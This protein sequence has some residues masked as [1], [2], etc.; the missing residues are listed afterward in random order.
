MKT[1]LGSVFVIFVLVCCAPKGELPKDRN[2][3]D[4]SLA[5]D[6]IKV[7]KESELKIIKEQKEIIL[8][9]EA[10]IEKANSKGMKDEIRKD[11]FMHRAALLKAEQNSLNQDLIINE[12]KMKLDSVKALEEIGERR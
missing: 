3:E 2:A 7:R 6:G 5:I 4:I 11:I 12:L 1:S 10:N 9:L 8:Q